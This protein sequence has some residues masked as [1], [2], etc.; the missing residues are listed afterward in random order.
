MGRAPLAY[1]ICG[2]SFFKMQNEEEGSGFPTVITRRS[3][4]FRSNYLPYFY[5]TLQK[6][7][8]LTYME[9]FSPRNK[10]LLMERKRKKQS[11]KRRIQLMINLVR[12]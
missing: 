1:P 9:N 7:I 5:R 4:I 6:Q 11:I 8:V 3:T 10:K 12:L 2:N